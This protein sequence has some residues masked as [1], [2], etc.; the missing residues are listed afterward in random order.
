MYPPTIKARIAPTRLR[1]A[2]PSSWQSSAATCQVSTVSGIAAS[3]CAMFSAAM[4][5]LTKAPSAWAPAIA[6]A[7]GPDAETKTGLGRLIQGRCASPP[8]HAA[9]SPRRIARRKSVPSARSRIVDRPS[10]RLRVPL[11][12]LPRPRIVRPGARR[13]SEAIA[14]AKTAGWRDSRLVTHN[15]IR[16][17]STVCATIVAAT[18]GSIALP[19]VSAMPIRSKPCRSAEA[20]MRRTRSGVNGQKKKPICISPHKAPTPVAAWQKPP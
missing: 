7:R 4:P 10:P 18:H 19:G 20:A 9:R 13:S 14:A 5:K 1:A 2:A 3:V 8:C 17:R 11:C 12:P 16:A 6:R 15:A